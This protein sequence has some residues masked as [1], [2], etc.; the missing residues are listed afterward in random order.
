MQFSVFRCWKSTF[1]SR[2]MTSLFVL[3]HSHHYFTAYR[4]CNNT[5]QDR[6]L[7]SIFALNCCWKQSFI[8]FFIFLLRGV[9]QNNQ[10]H[11]VKGPDWNFFFLL[12]LF[13]LVFFTS[14]HMSLWLKRWYRRWGHTHTHTHAISLWMWL[15]NLSWPNQT[16]PLPF[17]WTWWNEYQIG[18]LVT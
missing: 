10:Q 5:V 8:L 4:S 13:L 14:A 2:Q 17:K 9:F 11:L 7:V 16:S 12:L 6:L 3:R 18:L 1:G 15:D